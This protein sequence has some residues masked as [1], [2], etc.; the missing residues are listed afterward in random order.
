MNLLRQCCAAFRFLTIIPLPGTFGTDV[1]D[2]QGALPF[3]PV[4]GIVLGSLS[5]CPFPELCI[6]TAW[7]IVPMGFSV[8]GSAAGCWK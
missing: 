7:P 1:E 4:V 6:S 3:F 5:C 2:L 8:H